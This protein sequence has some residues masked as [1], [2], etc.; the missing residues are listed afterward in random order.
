MSLQV[1]GMLLRKEEIAYIL[2]F[3]SKYMLKIAD[4]NY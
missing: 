3:K 2:D 4:Q 1:K